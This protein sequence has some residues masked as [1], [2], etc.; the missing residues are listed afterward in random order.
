MPTSETPD[1]PTEADDSGYD[2]EVTVEAAARWSA[3]LEQRGLQLAPAS[4]MTMR[5]GR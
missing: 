2:E 5:P 4:A 3:G 1:E